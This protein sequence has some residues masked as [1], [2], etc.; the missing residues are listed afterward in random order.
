VTFASPATT[1]C[2]LVEFATRRQE[3]FGISRGW[4]GSVAPALLP[5]GFVEPFL[6]SVRGAAPEVEAVAAK[7]APSAYLANVVC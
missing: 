1:I 7:A 3:E 5:A 2:E 4:S 6:P